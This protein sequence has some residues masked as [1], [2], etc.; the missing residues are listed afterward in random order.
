[1]GKITTERLSKQGYHVFAGC[2]LDDSIKQWNESGNGRVHAVKL[3]VTSDESVA[4]AAETVKKALQDKQKY[5]YG[6]IGIINCAGVAFEG[7]ISV[8]QTF[9]CLQNSSYA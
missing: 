3:D 7:K 2:Y 6:L 8:I 4:A 1:M 5:K 9:Y